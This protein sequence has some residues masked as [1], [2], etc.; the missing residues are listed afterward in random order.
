MTCTTL[1]FP[2]DV[3]NSDKC[4]VCSCCAVSGVNNGLETLLLSYQEEERTGQAAGP[5]LSGPIPAGRMEA[6]QRLHIAA[7][8]S[9]SFM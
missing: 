9:Y 7:T 2:A 1:G 3:D 8:H 4:H 6:E 5:Q